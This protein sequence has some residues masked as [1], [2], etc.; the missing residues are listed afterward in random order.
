MLTG[1]KTFLTNSIVFT[2]SM[3]TLLTNIATV[4]GPIIGLTPQV[5]TALAMALAGLS[6][7][8]I[9]LR[10][11]TTTPIFTGTIEITPDES[12]LGPV[13]LEEIAASIEELKKLQTK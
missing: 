10:F 5:A 13:T 8:N 11:L 1:Y 2:A 6:A 9:F 4:Y 3:I 12:L 7:L